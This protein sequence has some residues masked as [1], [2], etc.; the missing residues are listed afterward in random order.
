[1]N[2]FLLLWGA[3]FASIFACR[4]LPYLLLHGRTLSPRVTDALG[5]IPPAAFAALVANDL[6]QPEA[7][8]AGLLSGAFPLIATA[9]VA[10]VA[11]R[12]RSMLWCCVAGVASYLALS[13]LV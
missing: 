4:T 10:L 5:F 2:E 7:W 13:L 12:T 3:A 8:S 1:M 6:I 9:I 11:V